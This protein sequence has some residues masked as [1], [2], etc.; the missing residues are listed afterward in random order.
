MQA[1]DP[2][3]YVNVIFG[4]QMG[5]LGERD[6]TDSSTVMNVSKPSGSKIVDGK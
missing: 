3:I 5:S 6:A 1:S 2:P 4:T